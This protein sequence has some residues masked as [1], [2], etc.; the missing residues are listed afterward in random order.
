MV[1]ERL[2]VKAKTVMPAANQAK[3]D[4]LNALDELEINIKKIATSHNRHIFT[5]N[6]SRVR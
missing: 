5:L 4:M 2:L 6:K 3:V 1:S